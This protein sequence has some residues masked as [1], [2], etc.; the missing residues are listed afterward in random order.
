[1]SNVSIYNKDVFSL[2]LHDFAEKFAQSQRFT[3]DMLF[4]LGNRIEKLDKG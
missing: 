2:F 3:Q 1:M 4:D